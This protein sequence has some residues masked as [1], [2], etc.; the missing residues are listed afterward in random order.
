[1]LRVRL[2]LKKMVQVIFT[3]TAE[4]LSLPRFAGSD[5]PEVDKVIRALE[6]QFGAP[7]TPEGTE[8]SLKDQLL[9]FSSSFMRLLNATRIDSS[10]HF[11]IQEDNKFIAILTMTPDDAKLLETWFRNLTDASEG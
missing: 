7:S 1:M 5:E 6:G 4:E 2:N 9:V 11:F 3:A 8:G 10:S